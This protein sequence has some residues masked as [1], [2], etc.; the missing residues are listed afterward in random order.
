MGLLEVIKE[1]IE[2]VRQKI[3]GESAADSIDEVLQSPAQRNA[4]EEFLVRVAREIDAELSRVKIAAPKG[5]VLLPPKFIVFLNTQYDEEW[6]GDRRRFLEE[7][8]TDSICQR[9]GDLY[10]Q[11]QTLSKP[12]VVGL[13]VDGTL[14][15]NEFRVRA[16][17]DGAGGGTTFLPNRAE[18]TEVVLYSVEVSRKGTPRLTIPI[19]KREIT[20]GRGLVGLPLTEDKQVSRAHAK[21]TLDE[22][23]KL[24]LTPEGQNPTYLSGKLV[25]NGATVRVSNNRQ[26]EIESYTLLV[27]LR[28]ARSPR[29]SSSKGGVKRRV[30]SDK[31]G[32]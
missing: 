1:N 16:I 22:T 29:R 20:I 17:W 30:Q 4:A 2:T 28:S 13:R 12:I 7:T 5:G 21:L 27:K 3:D 15:P 11:P 6:R 32:Q 9:A 25:K 31:Q 24:W 23:G 18:S 19:S 14:G 10:G 8:L 26:I